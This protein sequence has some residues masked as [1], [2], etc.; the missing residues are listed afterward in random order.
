MAIGLDYFKAFIGI[1]AS[2]TAGDATLQIYLDNAWAAFIK[3]VGRDIVQTTYP[4]APDV[5]TGD[6]GFYS[7]NGTR[8]LLLRQ[9]PAIVS[10]LTVYLDGSGR[11]GANPDGAFASTTQLVYGRDYIL[12]LD[13]CLPGTSTQCSYSGILE[14]VGTTWPGRS[15]YSVGDVTLQPTP[16]QGNIKIV[17]TAGWP[18]IPHDIRQAVC[19]IAAYIRRNADKGGSMTSESLGGYS[20]SLAQ[21]ATSGTVPELGS[22]RSVVAAYKEVRL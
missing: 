11:F 6:S 22:L 21:Q 2:N 9:R 5:G 14:R 4:A 17:Y 8:T 15:A 12:R 1:A 16:G 20:Y 7:G 13:G 19:Q 3:A 10:G 18:T